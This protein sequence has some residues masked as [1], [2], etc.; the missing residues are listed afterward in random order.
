MIKGGTRRRVNLDIDETMGPSLAKRP[1]NGVARRAE[2]I[3]SGFM[4]KH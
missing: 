4:N 1:M 2:E 3:R